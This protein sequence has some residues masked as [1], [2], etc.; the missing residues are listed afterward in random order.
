MESNNVLKNNWL[1]FIKIKKELDPNNKFKKKYLEEELFGK[2]ILTQDPE[3][4]NLI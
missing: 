2:N 1:K 4:V 3:E